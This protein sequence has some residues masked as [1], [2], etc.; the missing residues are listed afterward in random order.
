MKNKRLFV[1]PLVVFALLMPAQAASGHTATARG[2]VSATVAANSV[3]VSMVPDCEHLTSAAR[4]HILAYGLALCGL[5]PVSE[6]GVVAPMNTVGGTCGTSTILLNRISA[7]R[8]L[9]VNY[10]FYSTLG[11]AVARTL[12]V[13]VGST[14]GGVGGWG[15]VSPMFNYVY[16]TARLQTFPPGTA[17]AALGGTITLVWGLVCYMN[18]PTASLYV[19]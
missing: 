6:P 7:G 18:G 4:A 15:D 16:S 14:G 3:R 10:G 5:N 8:T 17:H 1:I 9:S 2:A 13:S 19:Q 11:N 12:A